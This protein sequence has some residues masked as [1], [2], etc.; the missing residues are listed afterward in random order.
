[1]Q[2]ISLFISIINGTIN[3]FN[4][5][6]KRHRVVGQIR[7]KKEDPTIYCLQ[8]THFRLKYTQRLKV[9]EWENIFHASGNQ[10]KVGITILNITQNKTVQPF[11]SLGY[12]PNPGI[13]PSS[14]TLQAESLPAEK[15]GKP[16][17]MVSR[18]K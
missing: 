7:K 10:K 18:D 2:S 12:L 16:P 17:K 5:P 15:Q 8:E 11:L 14:P 9:K 1:M 6:V 4:S 3:R 13:K